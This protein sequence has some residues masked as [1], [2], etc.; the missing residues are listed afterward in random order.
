[1]LA[2][3]QCILIICIDRRR[4]FLNDAF[5][6]L[7]HHI[8]ALQVVSTLWYDDVREALCRLNELLVHRFEH[9]QVAVDNHRHGASAVDSVALYVAYESLVGVAVD[10]DAQI[11][12]VAQALVEQCHNALHDNHRLRLHVYRLLLAVALQVRVRRLFDSFALAQLVNL[13]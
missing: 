10:E 3:K 11:H 4:L 5:D 2:L 9:L 13:L 1:M 7:A 8:D 12:H 6:V